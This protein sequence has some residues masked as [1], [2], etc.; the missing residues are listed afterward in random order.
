MPVAALDPRVKT[1]ITMVPFISGEV[2]ALFYPDGY[3]ERARKERQDVVSG[4]KSAENLESVP[5]F[6]STRE[7]A[8]QDP[9]ANVMGDP[10]TFDFYE[11]I[12]KRSENAGFAWENKITLQ[13]LYYASKFEPIIYLS[14]IS[15]KPLL[16][17]LAEYDRFISYERQVR[18]FEKAKEPK[19]LVQ[20]RSEHF[21]T[22][23]G[24]NFEENVKKQ[25]EFLQEFL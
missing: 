19:K 14:R 11:T 16:Y 5:I 4:I 9:F 12:R 25:I 15:P 21:E 24:S 18:A 2:D 8:V 22:Y 7:E 3:L 1:V 13:S 23:S 20:I 10:E 17:I 6:A